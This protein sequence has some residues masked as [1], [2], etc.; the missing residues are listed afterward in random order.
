MPGGTNPV[1]RARENLNLKRQ[2]YAEEQQRKQQVQKQ[3]REVESEFRERDV[4]KQNKGIQERNRYF[5][6][7]KTPDKTNRTDLNK[8][9]PKAPKGRE[10]SI[11][12][13]PPPKPPKMPK[14]PKMPR[15]LKKALTP[16]RA[17]TTA[18]TQVK[19]LTG[20]IST[21]AKTKI[22]LGTAA[23]GALAA[24]SVVDQG[25]KTYQGL[26]KFYERWLNPSAPAAPIPGTPQPFTGGQGPILY[27]IRFK[28]DWNSTST[29]K[30]NQTR[31]YDT[32]FYGPIGGIRMSDRNPY[33]LFGEQGYYYV[34]QVL[35]QG[36]WKDTN[37]SN[38]HTLYPDYG[39]YDITVTPVD[40]TIN[41]SQWG[42]PPPQQPPTYFLPPPAPPIVNIDLS[43]NIDTVNFAPPPVTGAANR[44]GVAANNRPN[45][46]TTGASNVG[47]NPASQPITENQSW[48]GAPE[49]TVGDTA[50]LP[51]EVYLPTGFLPSIFPPGTGETA[52]SEETGP[53]PLITRIQKPTSYEKYVEPTSMEAVQNRVREHQEQW[54]RERGWD[55][56]TKMWSNERRN[57]SRPPLGR[58]GVGVGAGDRLTLE[59]KMALIEGLT[60]PGTEPTA[61]PAAVPE[62]LL[63]E[64]EIKEGYK[65]HRWGGPK[66]QAKKELL[67]Q[68]RRGDLSSPPGGPSMYNPLNPE[69]PPWF[70]TIPL[71][72]PPVMPVKDGSKTPD[73]ALDRP[74][75][76]DPPGQTKPSPCNNPGTC[77]GKIL[78]GQGA[79]GGVV[80]NNNTVI[81]NI[82]QGADLGLLKVID[83]KLGPQIANGGISSFMQRAWKTTRLDKV[84]N[85]LNTL[86][87]LH[88]AALLSRNLGQT[89]GDLTSTALSVFGIKDEND[90][91]IDINEILSDRIEDLAISLLGEEV[92]NNARETW[93]KASRIT[94]AAANLYYS[95]RM[96]ADSTQQVVEWTAENTGR[97]GNALKRFRVVSPNAY[98]WMTERVNS[99]SKIRQYFNRV[100]DGIDTLDDTAS[101]MEGVL[102]DVIDIQDEFGEW[103]TK[104]T[105]F[106]DSVRELAPNIPEN[107]EPIFEERTKAVT[108][109]QAPEIPPEDLN[110]DY[111]EE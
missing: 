26:R 81:N 20:P 17:V 60:Q 72:P 63:T 35:S 83:N 67:E 80:N 41:D 90:N 23:G 68:I 55:P 86:L 56:E 77:S 6:Q 78:S 25:I 93:N 48:G 51:P 12:P 58:A 27:R 44:A 31:I 70:P 45:P 74:K 14:L 87:L 50:G 53:P 52:S 62:P 21:V 46:L 103:D 94:S 85:A 88:N 29:R 96:I 69:K 57:W 111:P 110:Y 105:A 8:Q 106:K 15:P 66:N 9:R 101:S 36:V 47:T 3:L 109:S 61:P 4:N 11:P 92:Y 38:E 107:N 102:T 30:F 89:L 49:P 95:A 37:G 75:L 91:P 34:P 82:A 18:V 98:P 54:K 33:V 10:G 59:E 7:T 42:N 40:T 73:K 76:P 13:K 22:P 43:T 24:W 99:Q 32:R 100:R 1:Q 64:E 79:I 108:A 84:L 19:S 39:P 71:I 65:V 2:R 5:E 97:I 104:Q 28:W 16:P